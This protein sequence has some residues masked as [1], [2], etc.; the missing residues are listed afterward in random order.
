MTKELPNLGYERL[1][2]HVKIPRPF[3]ASV[4]CMRVKW[5]TLS[6][7]V[8]VFHTNIIRVRPSFHHRCHVLITAKNQSVWELFCVAFK[9][10]CINRKCIY[11][12]NARRTWLGRRKCWKCKFQVHQ[13]RS[14]GNSFEIRAPFLVI[15][16]YHCC[17]Y[18]QMFWNVYIYVGQTIKNWI[19]NGILENYR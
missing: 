13:S 12:C 6:I 17:S 1:L 11:V 7:I 4:L 9:D 15:S 8:I 3:H 5:S 19:M 18:S 14:F 16:F 2:S 10:T